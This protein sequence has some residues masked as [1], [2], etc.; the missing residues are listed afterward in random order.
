M[1]DIGHNGGPSIDGGPAAAPDARP[2]PYFPFWWEDFWHSCRDADMRPDE[3]GGFL[4]A[5]TMQWRE[6]GRFSEE[7]VRRMA[8]LTGWDIRTCRSLIGKL[9]AKRKL[10]RTN[11]GHL[12][13]ARMTEEIERFVAKKKA[14]LEREER[15]RLARV[16]DEIAAEIGADIGLEIAAEIRLEIGPDVSADRTENRSKINEGH[17]TEGTTASSTAPHVRARVASELQTLREEDAHSASQNGALRSPR[18]APRPKPTAEQWQRFWTEY[19]LRKGKIAAERTFM[20]LTP[21]DADAAIRAVQA[22]EADCRAS[23]RFFKWPQGWLR[24]RRFED[25]AAEDAQQSRAP[26]SANIAALSDAEQAALV[27]QECR[28][29]RYWPINVLGHPPGHKEC[30]IRLQALREAGI[31]PETFDPLTG[32]RICAL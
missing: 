28:A 8:V 10:L 5:L 20:A 7:E 16:V 22:Y 23:G 18:A 12:V 15:K 24:E 27:A 4:A 25:Y 31:R 3:I 11:D 32:M 19:P 6:F 14:A 30:A 13:N 2:P 26:V 1:S 9:L 17:S 21:E 29:A